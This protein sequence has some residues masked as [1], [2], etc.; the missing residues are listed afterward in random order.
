ML[1]RIDKYNP[2][3]TLCLAGE[4]A[5]FRQAFYVQNG[6]TSDVPLEMVTRGQNYA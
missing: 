4:G 6:K 5:D 3:A 1:N 2:D